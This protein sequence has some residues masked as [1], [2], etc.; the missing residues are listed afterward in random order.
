M[1]KAVIACLVELGEFF[2]FL[3]LLLLMKW[4][5][6]VYQNELLNYIIAH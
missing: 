4:V 6:L 1:M 2:K 5:G 3:V